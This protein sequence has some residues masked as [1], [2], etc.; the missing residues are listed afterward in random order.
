MN[1]AFI[2]LFFFCG[3]MGAVTLAGYFLWKGDRWRATLERVGEA[4]PSR[5]TQ[6]QR[7]QKQL[8]FAGYRQPNMPQIYGG[9]KTAFGLLLGAICASVQ[10][11]A[12]RD[13]S[14]VLLALV[15]GFGLGYLLPDQVLNLAVKRRARR[16][17]F[18]I[19]MAIDILVL[20][21]EAGQSLDSAIA[22]TARELRTASP[23]VSAELNLVRAEMLGNQSRSQ[24]FQAL[25]DRN[26][27]PELKRLAQV[28]LDSDR[29]GVSLAPA[30]RGHVKFLR[31]RLRQQAY[32][33]ARKVSVKLVFPVFFLIFPA[34]LL[35]TL[36]PAII[37][38]HNQFADLLGK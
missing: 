31:T 3:V 26:T 33:Q 32:E 36:G 25:R 6:S 30:L 8:S 34:V 18:G 1:P 4:V 7:Y 24:V 14:A 23:D 35:V 19:P 28:F 15:A 2:V 5:T 16:L 38:I 10:I 37:Q 13:L 22:E 20:S 27:E 29:F 9:L 11:F 12:G 21:L 17:L